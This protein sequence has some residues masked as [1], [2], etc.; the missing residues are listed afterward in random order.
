VYTVCSGDEPAALKELCDFARVCGFTIVAA[1]K[2]KNNPLDREATPERLSARA[3]TLGLNPSM[4][5]EFVDGSKTMVEMA[6]V[7][8]G[9]GLS[10][11]LRNMHGPEADVG[12]LAEVFRLRD[13][14]GIL[15]REGVVDYAIGDLAPGVFVVVRHE[16]PVANE[17]LR[18]L[19]VGT[20]PH[21]LLCRPYHLT[22]L[23]VPDT[24]GWAVIHGKPTLATIRTPVT[25]V[26]TLAKRDLRRG[27]VIDC[28]GGYTVYG[29]IENKAEALRENLL[30]L[31]LAIGATVNEDVEKG[32]ALTYEQV[33]L[34][35]STLLEYRRVQDNLYVEKS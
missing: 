11:D 14:G 19:K 17:T 18:Y 23:E 33:E 32:T 3:E 13:Q 26:I 7:A 20:G 22:N 8:N 28:L 10:V 35:P 12:E 1:G 34:R 24:V 31:G 6:C 29:G 30:P 25:E 15:G 21:Y 4:L 5:T 27:D 16:G 2:G 9:V